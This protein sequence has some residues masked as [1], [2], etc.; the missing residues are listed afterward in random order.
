MKK[1]FMLENLDCAHCAANIERA[2]SAID[3]IQS[4]SV[5][6]LTAK[7]EVDAEEALFPVLFPKIKKAV[8]QQDPDVAVKEL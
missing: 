3:G 1:T 2:V 5:N 7:M 4:A 6:F 8:V